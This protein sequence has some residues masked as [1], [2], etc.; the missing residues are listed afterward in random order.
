MFW[1]FGNTMSDSVFA[2][3]G[4]QQPSGGITCKL[5]AFYV[6]DVLVWSFTVNVDPERE[7]T[8]MSSWNEREKLFKAF[9]EI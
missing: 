2:R 7:G 8:E 4:E 5:F 9:F 3:V 1:V 6:V